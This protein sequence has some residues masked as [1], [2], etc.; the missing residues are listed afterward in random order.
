MYTSQRVPS[1]FTAAAVAFLINLPATTWAA[2]ELDAL[3]VEW[4][5]KRLCENLH[6]DDKI[7][8][9]RC[10]I[11][12]NATHVRHFHPAG[13]NYV[14]S[15]GKGRSTNAKGTNEWETETDANREGKPVEWH[16]V[17]NI[18]DTTQRYL[19]VEKKY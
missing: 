10:T 7:R 6:E 9:L 18:G 5:G 1:I 4:E 11:P 17:T 3:T 15:G 12:P 16:E 2:D 8:V 19:L 14:L 13:F